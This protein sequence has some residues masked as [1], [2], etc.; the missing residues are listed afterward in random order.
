MSKDFPNLSLGNSVWIQGEY[1]IL[2]LSFK[3]ETPRERFSDHSL[4]IQGLAILRAQC[5]AGKTIMMTRSTVSEQGY[6]RNPAQT[7]ANVFHRRNVTLEAQIRILL[8]KTKH[9]IIAR[10]DRHPIRF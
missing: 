8:A 9:K 1:S 3:I 5:N 6:Q 2:Q 7:R 4:F 10:Q